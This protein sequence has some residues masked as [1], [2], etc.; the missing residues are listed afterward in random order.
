MPQVRTSYLSQSG[1]VGPISLA[2]DWVKHGHVI[3]LWLVKLEGLLG[4][5]SQPQR[6]H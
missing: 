6:K 2:S 3:S 5:V 4:R 1:G